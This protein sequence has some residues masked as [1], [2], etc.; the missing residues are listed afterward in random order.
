MYCAGAGL[1]E[2][3]GSTV[4]SEVGRLWH[5]LTEIEHRAIRSERPVGVRVRQYEDGLGAWW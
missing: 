3:T 4:E 2:A 5:T 1:S